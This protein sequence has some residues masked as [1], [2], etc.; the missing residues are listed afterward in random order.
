M[1][2]LVEWYRHR[3][4]RQMT[5]IILVSSVIAFVLAVLVGIDDNPPGTLL[6]YLGTVLLVL[7]WVHAWRK[8][9][10]FTWLVAGSLIGIPV[11][12]VLHNLLHADVLNGMAENYLIIAKVLE[13]LS[14]LS[15]ILALAICPVGLVIGLLGV[16]IYWSVGSG[17]NQK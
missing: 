13:L 2:R 15:F 8:R 12:V 9:R 17:D 4:K 10:K 14:A 3:T 5:L 16:V 1:K 11:F 6:F 7:A